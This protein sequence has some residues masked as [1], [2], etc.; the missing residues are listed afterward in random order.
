[1]DKFR[2]ENLGSLTPATTRKLFTLAKFY[3]VPER[4]DSFDV[5][6]NWI[7]LGDGSR[8]CRGHLEFAEIRELSE[9]GRVE[10]L[11]IYSS[12]PSG[13]FFLH[14]I[15]TSTVSWNSLAGAG[16]F[17]HVRKPS[18]CVVKDGEGSTTPIFEVSPS[19]SPRLSPNT[20]RGRMTEGP[21]VHCGVITTDSCARGCGAFRPFA[22]A[23]GLFFLKFTMSVLKRLKEGPPSPHPPHNQEKSRPKAQGHPP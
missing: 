15:L 23:S 12:Q 2:T 14:F 17:W 5:L 9:L 6:K 8:F 7:Q 21:C 1:V 13:F 3:R 18:S 19:V 20:P 10:A 11:E 16:P 22:P 4:R